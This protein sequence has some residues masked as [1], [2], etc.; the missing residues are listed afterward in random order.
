MDPRLH[1]LQIAAWVAA[2]VSALAAVM[3]VG[4]KLAGVG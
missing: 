2:I 1:R 4:L 3:M